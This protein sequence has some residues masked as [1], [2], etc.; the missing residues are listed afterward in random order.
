MA[1]LGYWAHSLALRLPAEVVEQ[2]KLRAG[3]VC[4]VR[5]LD[6]GDIRIRLSGAAARARAAAVPSPDDLLGST[7]QVAKKW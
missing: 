5:L 2:A 4:S 7:E 1:T 6:S 3:D